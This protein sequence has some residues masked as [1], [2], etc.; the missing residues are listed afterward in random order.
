MPTTINNEAT[1][2]YRYSGSSDVSEIT[3]N[4]SSI[5]LEDAQG[6]TITKV[7]N[8]TTF[9]V[10]SI[11]TYTIQITNSSSSYLTGVRII[12]NLGGGN[13]AYVLGSG[14]LTVNGQSYP[15]NPVQT[16]PLTFAL[17]QLNVGQSMTLTYKSQVIFNLPSTVGSITNTVQGI[18]YTSTGTVNGFANSTIQRV[19]SS[20]FS[21]SKSASATNVFPRQPFNYYIT[22]T[23]TTSTIA[24]I[25]SITDQLPSNYVLTSVTLTTGSD[26]PVMLSSTDYTLSGSN[27]LTIPS[28]TGPAVN[29]PASSTT[30]V[31]LT[32]Y[33][34]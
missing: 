10:G 8:P 17:Q 29:V 14:S 3:S 22:L 30:V 20:D 18:G 6:L 1:T 31:T 5:V 27:L 32:G 28:S 24:R 4:E 15:V 12:D 13:L 21:I 26:S 9:S 7:A 2:S 23:N 16:N 11:I 25:Q 34:N 19:D 33:F